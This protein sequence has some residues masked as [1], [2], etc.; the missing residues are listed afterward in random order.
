MKCTADKKSGERCVNKQEYGAL[1]KVHA[2]QLACTPSGFQRRRVLRLQH[3]N[4]PEEW[5]S[6]AITEYLAEN[7]LS[8][9][10]TGSAMSYRWRVIE[11]LSEVE[12]LSA[13]NIIQKINEVCPYEL[14]HWKIGSLLRT[15]LREGTIA[16][17]STTR[18]GK[19]TSVYMMRSQEHETG[20]TEQ[21]N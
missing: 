10:R 21:A 2:R 4:S 6:N 19:S 5:Y 17:L 18:L 13:E 20:P 11:V 14:N 1:C 15:M 9:V 8:A 12:S 7:E 3:K 16:R